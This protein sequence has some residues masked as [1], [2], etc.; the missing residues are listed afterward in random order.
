MGALGRICECSFDESVTAYLPAPT[1]VLRR[2]PR[3]DTYCA[4]CG[5]VYDEDGGSMP[6]ATQELRAAHHFH[7]FGGPLLDIIE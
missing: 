4:M 3:A 7:G 1:S 2:F 5:A 6:E